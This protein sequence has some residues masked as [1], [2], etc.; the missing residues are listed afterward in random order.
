MTSKRKAARDLLLGTWK[1]VDEWSTNVEYTIRKKNGTYSVTAIDTYD[2]EKADIFEENWDKKKGVFSF[3]GYWNSTGRFMRCRIQ[4]IA[5][6]KID[7]TYTYTD[8]EPMIRKGKPNH[9]VEPTRA[10]A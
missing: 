9:A 3:A 10:R 6:D 5:K 2:N 1:S 8:S 7:F 4:L